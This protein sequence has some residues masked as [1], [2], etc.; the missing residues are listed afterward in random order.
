MSCEGYVH[1]SAP[2]PPK[3]A[4]PSKARTCS[5]ASQAEP[6]R[7]VPR[8]KRRRVNPNRRPTSSFKSFAPWCLESRVVEPC[9]SGMSACPC[10]SFG[11]KLVIG[12]PHNAVDSL[13]TSALLHRASEPQDVEEACDGL[14]SLANAFSHSASIGQTQLGDCPSQPGLDSIVHQAHIRLATQRGPPVQDSQKCVAASAWGLQVCALQF[15]L[16][17]AG[18]ASRRIGSRSSALSL[19]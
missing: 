8:A 6:S 15:G 3:T 5:S 4:K 2:K 7:A 17:C 16:F 11:M 14:A 12:D 1:L 18:A 19:L 10:L 9:L 13:Q